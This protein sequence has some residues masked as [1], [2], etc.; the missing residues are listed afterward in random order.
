MAIYLVEIFDYDLVIVGSGLAGLRAAIEAAKVGK[1]KLRIAIIA[2][3]QLMRP[4]SISAEGGSAAVLYTDEGD[5]FDLHAYDTIKGSDYLADQDAVEFFVR[6][7]PVDILELEHWGIPWARRE[8]GRIAQRPFGG[9]SYPRATFAADRTGF[10]EVHTLY[11]T[12]LK[13]GNIDKFHEQFVYDFLIDN[14]TFRGVLAFD[15]PTGEIRIFKARAAIIATGGLGRLYGYTTYSH[16]VTGDGL[17]IALRRG[18]RMKD[19]EFVQF[20]PTGLVP[21]GILITEGVRGDG[22]ILRNAKGERFMEKYAPTKKDLAPRDIIS[23]S[24]MTEILEGRGYK[25]P[26]GLDYLLLDFSPIGDEKIKEKLSQV[27]EIGIHYVGLDPLK[28]PLPVRPSAHYTMGGIDITTTGYTGVTGLWAAG[29]AGCISIHGSNRLGSNSTSECVVFGK[30]AGGDSAKW[31]LS[32]DKQVNLSE[33]DRAYAENFIADAY[34]DKG[35]NDPYDIKRELWKTMDRDA[36]VFRNEKDLTEGLKI[37]RGLIE[38]SGK[39][40]IAEKGNVYNQNLIAS[41]EMKNLVELAEVVIYSALQRKESRGSHF[42][43]DFPKRDDDN[44]LKHTIIQKVGGELK[45]S[46]KPVT[47]TKWK[48]EARVY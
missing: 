12:M 2:K 43:T 47:L 26:D 3:N 1:G 35:D 16:L 33:G 37:V 15:I 4:H 42:R 14:N 31:L 24:M 28:S 29:E 30:Q 19:L 44:Y 17:A 40:T 45:L 21:S 13:Y 48:P 8:D 39:I 46:Y 32:N 36:Y 11:D 6:Q 25:G 34:K 5:S 9:H 23:R 18:L 27:R 7:C 38:R 20:H 10:Y 41:L 22:G